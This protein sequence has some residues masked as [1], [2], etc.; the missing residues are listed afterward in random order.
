MRQFQVITMIHTSAQ[1][2]IGNASTALASGEALDEEPEL[3]NAGL[4]K[5]LVL[6]LPQWLCRI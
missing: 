4:T 2:P 6:L 1:K 3:G 5:S